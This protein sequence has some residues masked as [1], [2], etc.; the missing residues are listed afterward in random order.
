MMKKQDKKYLLLSYSVK[1]ESIHLRTE[2]CTVGN[3]QE[4]IDMD[5]ASRLGQMVRNTKANG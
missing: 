1:K 2:L 4:G 3:G 5:T